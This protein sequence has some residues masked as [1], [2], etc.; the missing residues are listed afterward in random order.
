LEP[1]IE[2]HFTAKHEDKDVPVVWTYRYGNGKIC[3][4]V[5]GHNTGTMY[6]ETYQ[7]IL[8]RGLEWASG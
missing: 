5:P 6:K 8:R 1:G 4:A 7:Q 3:Y 2:V